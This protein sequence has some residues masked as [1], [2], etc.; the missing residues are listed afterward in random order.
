MAGSFIDL[1]AGELGAA[2]A[3]DLLQVPRDPAVMR[4]MIAPLPNR[5]RIVR[6]LL[7]HQAARETAVPRPD[8]APSPIPR[9]IMQFWHEA[10]PP[11]EI[12][13]LVSGWRARNPDF[14]HTLFSDQTARAFVQTHY[15]GEWLRAYDYCRHA[16]LRADLFRYLYLLREGGLY[17]EAEEA[18]LGPVH[19]ALPGPAAIWLA[20]RAWL[21]QDNREMPVARAIASK[22]DATVCAFYLVNAPLA[23]VP[24]HRLLRSATERAVQ[25][26]LQAR[27]RGTPARVADATAPP[28][29]TEAVLTALLGSDQIAEHVAEIGLLAEWTGSFAA[30]ARPS[31]RGNPATWR[32]EHVP[33]EPRRPPPVNQTAEASPPLSVPPIAP[34]AQPPTQGPLAIAQAAI[35]YR[36]FVERF[37]ALNGIRS[38]VEIGCGDWPFV[39]FANLPGVHYT[40]FDTAEAIVQRN[41]AAFAPRRQVAFEIMPTDYAQLPTADLLLIKDLLQHLPNAEILRVRA[42]LLPRFGHALITNAWR[43]LN[44][45]AHPDVEAGRFRPL[46][47]KREPYSYPGAYVSENWGE[48]ER[49]RTLLVSSAKA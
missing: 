32:S 19:A 5:S 10:A 12:A 28:I 49:T 26:I 21:F 46:D 29:F 3:A 31:H 2:S 35:E 22:L 6:S 15:P 16:V 4:A 37:I 38:I 30:Q 13:E 43:R 17:V 23:T 34:P 40:G 42:E 27:S 20:P 44:A 24:G 25:A 8:A 47:L 39:R 11:D 1:L 48:W 18:C 9:K 36:A 41:R 33:P 7:L 45:P 14:A